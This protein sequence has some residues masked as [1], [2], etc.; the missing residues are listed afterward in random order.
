MDILNQEKSQRLT[1]NAPIRKPT[2]IQFG[3]MDKEN[4][5]INSG[6]NIIIEDHPKCNT[7]CNPNFKC[8]FIVY[9]SYCLVFKL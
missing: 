2:Q 6:Q 5:H 3:N 7:L 4:I 1:R 8:K 9:V